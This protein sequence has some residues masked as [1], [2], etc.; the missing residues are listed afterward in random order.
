MVKGGVVATLLGIFCLVLGQNFFAITS[1]QAKTRVEVNIFHPGSAYNIDSLTSFENSLGINF[2]SAKWYQDWATNFD[3]GVAN[4]FNSAGFTP[5]LTWEPSE[6]GAGVSYQEVIDGDYDSYITQTANSIKNLGY[7]IRISLAPE[8][9]TDWTPWGIGKHGNNASNHKLFWK[10]VVQ[11][12]RDAGATNVKWIWSPN[13]R[14]WNAASLYG[15]YANIFPG[16]SYV[17]YMGLDGYNW[18]TSYSWA[19]WQSFRQVFES[20]YNELIGVSSRNI[21]IMEMAS[22][23][24]GGNKAKWI[25]DMFSTL[26]S[27]FPR[28]VGFTWFNI[29][30]ETDWRIN[31]S[32]ASQ[33][34]FIAGYKGVSPATSSSSP[35]TDSPATLTS[36]QDNEESSAPTQSESNS[37]ASTKTVAEKPKAKTPTVAQPTE[38]VQSVPEKLAGSFVASRTFTSLGDLSLDKIALILGVIANCLVLA[39]I[40]ARRFRHLLI[41][42]E[43]LWVGLGLVDS[44]YTAMHI[45]NRQ[46]DFFK[47]IRSGNHEE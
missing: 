1:A 9:N 26:Q 25:T 6:S 40:F 24:V 27:S 31:S 19:S 35:A 39:F 30:K 28:I 38:V 17:D 14:P 21:L 29:N 43:P 36:A 11:K 33:A 16:S 18:G 37:T 22:S 5:E 32:S 7:T 34:A 8:M 41:K 2:T 23:E 46:T 10:Y 42:H 47:K 13:V 4:R 45:R 15:S 20:S 12:F 44:V 3:P